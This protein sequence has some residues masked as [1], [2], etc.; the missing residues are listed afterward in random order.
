MKAS[1]VIKLHTAYS[2]IVQEFTARQLTTIFSPYNCFQIKNSPFTTK[3][4][5][6][7]C[8]IWPWILRRSS[9]TLNSNF[10][11]S[12][13]FKTYNLIY[14]QFQ[15]SQWIQSQASTF[16]KELFIWLCACELKLL[17]QMRPTYILKA[18]AEVA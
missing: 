11:D 5:R 3:S 2:M 12:T 13:N 14:M 17:G 7:Q 1:S 4:L 8:T 9:G 18:S 15:L 10:F 16:T 6:G